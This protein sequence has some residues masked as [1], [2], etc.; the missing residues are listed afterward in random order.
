MV[1]LS[2]TLSFAQTSTFNTNLQLYDTGSSVLSLQQFLN[3]HGYPVATSGVGSEGQET[4]FFGLHTYQALLK[5]QS[6]H[7]LP[8]TGFFGPLTRADINSSA[9]T[10][11]GGAASTNPAAVTTSNTPTT[12]PA[13][14]APPTSPTT[15][16]QCVPGWC[17]LPGYA[18]G[19]IVG[20]GGAN[21][22]TTP[23]V[24]SGTP[25]N[26]SVSA[27]SPSGAVVTYTAPTATDNIDGTDTVSCTPASGS[28]F[29]LGITTVTC[30]ATDKAGNSSSS[31]F[32]VTVQ[33]TTAPSVSLTL[34][35]NGATVGGTSVTLTATASDSIGAVAN[36]QFE[37]DTTKIGSAI[38]SSPY[39]TT[40][41]STG[42]A[43]GPHTLYA[44]AKNTAG[45][46]AT[47]SINVTVDNTAPVISAIASSSIASTTQTIT[48]TTNESATSKISYGLTTSYGFAS[49]SA[50]LTTSHSITLKGLTASTTYNFVVTSADASGNTSTSTNQ[51]F[52]TAA[53]NYYVDSVNGN[54]AN[55]GTSPSLALKDITALP[56]INTGQSVGLAY[57][58]NWRQQLT[59]NAPNVTVTG[60]GSGARPILDAS[61]VLPNAN[62]TKTGGYTNVYNTGTI[63]FIEGGQAAWANMWETGGPSDSSTGTFLAYETSIAS[64]DSTVCSFYIPTMTTGVMPS[65]QPIYIHSCDG[66]NP[67]TNGYTYEF[68]NRAAGLYMNGYGGIVSNIETRKNAY[69]DGSLELEGNGNSYTVT[70]VIVR[71]GGKH[72][73]LLSAGSTMASSTLIDGYYNGG[74]NL[75]VIYEASGS[76]L[77]VTLTNNIFQQDQ[78]SVSASAGISHTTSGT[79]GAI[80]VNGGYVIALN[81]ASISGFDFGNVTGVT[82]NNTIFDQANLGARAESTSTAGSLTATGVQYVYSGS[83]SNNAFTLASGANVT[84]TNNN[85]CSTNGSVGYGLVSLYQAATSTLTVSGGT[86][87]EGGTHIGSDTTATG[88]T[89]NVSNHLFDSPGGN[90]SSYGLYSTGDTFTGNNNTYVSPHMNR[91][92]LNGV[93]YT[94]LATW[95]TAVAPQDSSVTTTGSGLSACTLPTIPTVN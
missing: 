92:E 12:I 70:N 55:P 79:M 31:S 6:A 84:L 14:T 42:V 51:S 47:S 20:G 5:F 71:D 89:I 3:T 68:A 72:N 38:T 85:L 50:V 90:T 86:S 30:S 4:T 78:G 40:W 39:T 49:S 52:T 93:L 16:T 37:V 74:P 9:P 66:T 21:R 7:N 94:T 61:D 88:L 19:Q 80:T 10:T 41:N 95:Q 2:P 13:T 91:W 33:Q 23:P 73:M 45:Y 1:L 65:S 18:P 28:T 11:A 27:T 62:F 8:T 87:Y 64:V 26:L 54:N 48:W 83:A 43:D 56:T 29:A 53:Y 57:G 22:D 44:V 67:I 82:I 60:Y 46:Y 77:P 59:I 69:N 75:F 32:T 63:T 17:T 76:G 24:I 58:S 36:V 81:G 15:T 25:S 35:S 34:P